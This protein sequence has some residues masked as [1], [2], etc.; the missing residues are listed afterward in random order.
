MRTYDVTTGSVTIG[1]QRTQDGRFFFVPFLLNKL[2]TILLQLKLEPTWRKGA[3][4]QYVPM[5]SVGKASWFSLTSSNLND[6]IGPA[7]KPLFHF[8]II[9]VR[10][11]LNV[12]QRTYAELDAALAGVVQAQRLVVVMLA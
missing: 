4:S 2:L 10:E 5:D 7:K 8:G 11:V 9:I 12:R 6:A 1:T 3:V